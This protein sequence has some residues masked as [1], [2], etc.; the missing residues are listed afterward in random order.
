MAP[1]E[2]IPF[3]QRLQVSIA[4]AAQLLSFSE[5]TLYRLIIRGEL[6]SIGRGKLRRIAVAELKRWQVDQQE[7]AA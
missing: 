5:R 4:D 3:D 1:R 6:R 2:P 7:R